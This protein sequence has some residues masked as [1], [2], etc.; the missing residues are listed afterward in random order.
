[1]VDFTDNKEIKSLEEIEQSIKTTYRKKIWSKFIKAVKEFNLVEDGDK[2]AIGISGGK[3]SLLLAKLFQELKK[4]KSKNFEVKFITMNPGFEA[5]DLEQLRKNLNYLNIPC[6]I[7]EAN[8][9]EA[10][11]NKDP[12][13][14]CFL[15]AKMRRGVLYKKVEELGCNKMALG[16]HFDDVIETT[17]INMFY[18]GTVKTMLPKVKSTSD[19]LT[20]IR[21]L[22]Y[23]KEQDIINYTKFNSI[24]PMSCGCPIEAEKTPSKRKKIKLLLKDLAE[25]DPDIKQRIFN[26]TRNI[27]LDYI[28]GYEKKGKKY[29]NI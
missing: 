3:D 20:L 16:H 7:F 4:D 9:W 28:L 25:K 10:A 23:V 13:N 1:M 26:S 15:C 24:N 21:P 22:F 8:V 11:F 18:A 17:L 5:M 14:P 29:L 27:N 19:K 2:I 6:E 12:D